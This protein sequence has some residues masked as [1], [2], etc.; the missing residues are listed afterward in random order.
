MVLSRMR[1]RAS[2]SSGGAPERRGRRGG[3]LAGLCLLALLDAGSAGAQTG[4]AAPPAPA[5]TT[6]LDPVVVRGRGDSLVGVADTASQGTIGAA[7]LEARPLYRPGELLEAVPGLIVTQHSGEGKANQF[8]L[9]GF[10]LDHGTDFATSIDG[11]PVNL[12]SHGHGQGY[13]DLNFLI[14]ELV[15]RIDFHK[16]PYFAD[17]G[18]FSSAGAANLEYFDSLPETIARAEG[19]MNA[20]A[21]GLFASSTRIGDGNLLYAAEL[22]HDNGPWEHPDHYRKVNGVMRYSWGDA[23]SGASLTASAYAAKWDATDQIAKRALGLPGFGRLD[24]LDTSDGGNSQKYMLYG[25]WHRGS[26]ASASKVLLYGFYQNLDLFS[27]FTYVLSSPVGDQ[28]EQYDRRWVG[29]ASGR[30]TWYGSLAERAMEN[31]LGLEVRSD[32]IQNGLLQTV[33]RHRTDKPDYAGGTIPGTTRRDGIW[34]A[35]VSPWLENRAQWLEP[36]RSVVGVRLDYFHFDVDGKGQPA[37]SGIDDAV[38]VSPKGSL[39]LGPFAQTELY[40]SGGMGFHSNDAR[41]VTAPVDPADPLVRTYG[42][43]LGVRSTRVPGLQSTVAFWWLDIDS[44]LI[45]VGDAGTTEASRPSRR[46]GIEIA[47]YWSPTEWLTFDADYSLSHARF[48]DSDPAGDYIPGSIENVVAAGATVHGLAG[49]TG[50]LRL[51]YFGPRPLTE[52]DS[53][54]SDDTILVSTRLSYQLTPTWAVGVE[55]F[56][57]LDRDDSDI[58]YYYPSRLPGEPAGPDEG[59]FNDVHFHPVSPITVRAGVTA[60]F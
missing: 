57:L 18:D 60:R 21:R 15:E 39:V 35:S 49:F 31:T 13:T 54:R 24:S 26:D 56:N 14:P 50:E 8:F 5:G 12:P 43:E 45:F 20:Y 23:G 7:Q 51:R 41:G 34:E 1:R 42:A 40:L 6:R 11:V 59:G 29:G 38:R 25:E 36:L 28:F 10:N 48:R 9:R 47:N 2:R 17:E 44:E 53:V 32:S 3:P 30:H 33:R 46:Y 37:N 22:L 55:I 58:E 27:N 52:D 16:G 19:G 4:P